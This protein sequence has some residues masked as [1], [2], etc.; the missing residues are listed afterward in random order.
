MEAHTGTLSQGQES[1]HS[2]PTRAIPGLA[3]VCVDWRSGQGRGIPGQSVVKEMWGAKE[4]EAPVSS[5]RGLFS[6]GMGQ[7]VTASKEWVREYP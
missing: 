4:T 2:V 3:S 5:R 6:K 1:C 7:V